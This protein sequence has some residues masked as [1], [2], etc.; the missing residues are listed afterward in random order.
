MVVQNIN[1]IHGNSKRFLSF[2]IVYVAHI[3]L[4]SEDTLLYCSDVPLCQQQGT[5]P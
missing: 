2:S 3:G 1:R 4:V 5:G